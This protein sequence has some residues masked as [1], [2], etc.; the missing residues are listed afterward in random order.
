MTSDVHRYGCGEVRDFLATPQET[1]SCDWE[2]TNPPFRLGEE[3]ITLSIKLARRGVA[4]LART[5]FIE[6]AWARYERLFL[7]TPHARVA[8]FTE[9]VPMIKGRLDRSASTATGYAWL[10]WEKE[11]SDGTALVWIPPCRK[12]LERGG[13]YTTP[14]KPLAKR[15]RA[16]G[17]E[18]A[19]PSEAPCCC[20]TDKPG[21]EVCRL[22]TGVAAVSL[23]ALC[24]G[25]AS[26]VSNRSLFP[27]DERPL[28]AHSG[29]L[30]ST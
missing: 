26:V 20:G 24:K 22:A 21:G 19:R 27:S 10:V 14:A 28:F 6:R 16:V 7:T 11:R 17:V 23:L 25:A 30:E 5:V 8:Q 29:R 12:H 18:F 2:I 15:T 3:F 13:D 1:S 9:R 4:M